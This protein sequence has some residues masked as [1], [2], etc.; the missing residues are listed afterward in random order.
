MQGVMQ[1]F[2]ARFAFRNTWIMRCLQ[3][4]LASITNTVCGDVTHLWQRQ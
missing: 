3:D 4:T 1:T 2:V